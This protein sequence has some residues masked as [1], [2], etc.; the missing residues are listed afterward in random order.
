MILR[1]LLTNGLIMLIATIA[2]CTAIEN[3]TTVRYHLPDYIIPLHYDAK[4]RFNYK[5]NDIVG[6]CN[7]TIYSNRQIENIFMHPMTF[8]IFK[9]VLYDNL[10]SEKIYVPRFSFIN[11]QNMFMIDF[12]NM[13]KL[14]KYLPPGRYTLVISYMRNVNYNKE[15]PITSLFSNKKMDNMLIATGVDIMTARQLFPCWDEI[16]NSTFKIS[17]KHHKNYTALSN[18]PIQTTENDDKRDMMWT[19]FEKSPTIFIQHLKVVI[20]TF[21]NISTS[22]NVTFWGRK[23]I[24]NHLKLA[25]CIA[26]QILQFFKYENSMDKLPK[27]DY[28]AFWDN[29]HNNS[30]TWGLISQREVD[31]IY[32]EDSDSVGHK[33]KVASFIT[34]QI[35]SLWYDDVLL[36]SKTNF[37]TLLATHI[38]NQILPNDIMNLFIVETQRD[39]FLFDTPSNANEM[40]SLSYLLNHTK[41]S[42]IW[43]M[44]C[45]LLTADVFWTDIRTYV[46][47]KQYNKTNDFWNTMLTILQTIPHNSSVLI[48]RILISVWTMKIYYYP[49]LYVTRNNI[50]HMTRFEY[51]T[52][53]FI[54]KKTEF[55]PTFVTYTTK[56]IMNFH[57]I[58]TNK[59]FWLSPDKPVTLKHKFDENDWILVNLQQTGYYRVNYNSA[60]WEKL[61]EYMNSTTFIDIHVLN[62]AQIIDDA[63]HFFIHT[64][65][66][67]V[68]FWK[69]SAFLSQETNYIVWYPML[70]AF[71]Y[72]TFIVSIKDAN[73]VMKKM[74][75]IL[76][77][78]LYKIGYVAQRQES[79][80]T[81]RLREETVK[82]TC[83]IGNKKC[84][85]VA[86]EQ[87]IRDLRENR[88]FVTQSEW[89]RWMY[90]NG[91]VSANSTIWYDVYNKWTATPDDIK[92]LEY[93]TCSEDPGVISN[94]LRLNFIDNILLK[95]NTRAHIFLLTVARHARNN[96]VCDF[97]LQN[98][99]NNTFMFTSNTQAD[100]VAILIV[101][102]THQHAVEQLNKV[103]EFAKVNLREE[104]LVNAVYQKY[105]K[106]RFEYVRKIINYGLIG[107]RRFK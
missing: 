21:T 9:I 35:I 101:I 57:D 25:E 65:L 82:W 102:I 11:K 24:T 74:E 15:F 91:L 39:S 12:T 70:K 6:A 3:D 38:F 41:P 18:M 36:W 8:A 43:R 104:R 60:N 69:I 90:C 63:F 2:L 103:R 98:L 86:N 13:P 10:F 88:T 37:L 64:Q 92:F 99:N 100:I 48:V 75:E 55:P 61:A 29:Y 68:T 51:L 1:K 66:D 34:Y 58:F 44:L 30:M 54:D 89:K 40:S 73:D 23:N 49:V 27:I 72:V 7:I 17:I 83:I 80:F 105:K 79:I 42:N 5:T 45:H 62:R 81:E 67:Y 32:D 94:Y 50:T 96:I 97:I 95:R 93:L 46:T 14:E 71:E 28:V 26:Q 4:I 22:A 19:H 84:R 78:V 77:G 107:F 47:N 106:R 16:L 85:E 59:S 87:M 52:S 56:S 53:D 20:T 76:N 33:L 31:I